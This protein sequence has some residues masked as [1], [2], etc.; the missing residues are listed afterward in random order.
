[1]A[2]QR[3]N[4]NTVNSR[5]HNTHCCPPTPN[6]SSCTD[7]L[8]SHLEATEDAADATNKLV[9]KSTSVKLQDSEILA[10]NNQVKSQINGTSQL[11][12]NH[13]QNSPAQTKSPRSQSSLP[14]LLPITSQRPLPNSWDTKGSPKVGSSIFQ[15]F[16]FIHH[17]SRS[18]TR[19]LEYHPRPTPMDYQPGPDP[20][21]AG[22][23]YYSPAPPL[24]Q[25]YNYSRAGMVILTILSLAKVVVPNLG[26]YCPSAAGLLYLTCSA[27]FLYWVLMMC[28]L[29]GLSTPLVPWYMTTASHDSLALKIKKVRKE[30]IGNKELF[31]G[32][33]PKTRGIQLISKA[34]SK[35]KEPKT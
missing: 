24:P 11:S 32:K 12:T 5:I 7:V 27:P 25:P 20:G 33:Q 21:M 23:P 30:N 29:D 6:Q 17:L 28:Y 22:I 9:D 1:M 19:R 14:K 3:Q 8:V 4:Q 26:A 35:Y 13:Q 18:Q 10:V 31:R 2:R 34:I 16:Q 15:G